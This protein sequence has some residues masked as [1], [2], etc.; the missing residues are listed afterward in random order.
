MV[1]CILDVSCILLFPSLTILSRFGT[2]HSTWQWHDFPHYNAAKD[3]EFYN[4]FFLMFEKGLQERTTPICG[5]GQYRMHRNVSKVVIYD[6]SIAT[7]TIHRKSFLNNCR[8]SQPRRSFNYSKLN[9]SLGT[10]GALAPTGGWRLHGLN[11]FDLS[12]QK[13]AKC[14]QFSQQFPWQ[15]IKKKSIHFPIIQSLNLSIRHFPS[16]QKIDLAGNLGIWRHW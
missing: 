1:R 4:M 5:T 11:W 6:L 7:K 8:T 15:Q 13:R 10:R 2:K 9:P 3:S 12:L 16:H 14:R